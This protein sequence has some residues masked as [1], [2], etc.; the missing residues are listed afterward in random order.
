[1]KILEDEGFTLDIM[2][3]TFWYEKSFKT[4]AISDFK[5]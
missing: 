4:A 3:F 2:E 1:M 5:W